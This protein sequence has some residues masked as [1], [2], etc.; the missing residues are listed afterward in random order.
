MDSKK[1]LDTLAERYNCIDFKGEFRKAQEGMKEQMK[2]LYKD[3]M[4]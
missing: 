1:Q 2:M 4:K 3:F